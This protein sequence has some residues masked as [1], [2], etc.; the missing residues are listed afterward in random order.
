ML[1]LDVAL[2]ESGPTVGLSSQPKFGLSHPCSTFLGLGFD[3]DLA[4]DRAR[5]FVFVF[6]SCFLWPMHMPSQERRLGPDEERCVALSASRRFVL[7]VTGL[8]DGFMVVV[9]ADAVAPA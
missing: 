5:G 1:K 7:V 2:S 3:L 9:R 6:V 4:F 8:D